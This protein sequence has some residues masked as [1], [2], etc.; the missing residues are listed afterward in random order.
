ML[1]T[2]SLES[3]TGKVLFLRM[4][5]EKAYAPFSRD[6]NSAIPTLVTERVFS[7]AWQNQMKRLGERN[8]NGKD[9][10]E[11]RKPQIAVRGKTLIEWKRQTL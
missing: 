10:L 5:D 9:T 6:L 7:F 8:A 2:E 3:L 1:E 11:K 4:C